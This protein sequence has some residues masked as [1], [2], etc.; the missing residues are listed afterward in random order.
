M[1]R[2]VKE[3]REKMAQAVNAAKLPPVVALLVL[4]ALRAELA[5]FVRK[6]EEVEEKAKPRGME[7][8]AADGTVSG[9]GKRESADRPA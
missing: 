1:V 9:T 2:E 5:E 7:G 4:D 8:G 6:Q 3:L